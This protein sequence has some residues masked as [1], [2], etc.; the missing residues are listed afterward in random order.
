MT[1]SLVECVN[2]FVRF[3]CSYY[4]SLFLSLAALHFGVAFGIKKE[5]ENNDDYVRVA[6][7][8]KYTFTLQ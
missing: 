6:T 1:H 5:M 4:Y 7:T 8:H 3:L 2:V